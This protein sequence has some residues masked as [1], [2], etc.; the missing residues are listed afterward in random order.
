MPRSK[1]DYYCDCADHEYLLT[2]VSKSTWLCHRSR[3]NNPKAAAARA[4]R[5]LNDQISSD[6]EEGETEQGDARDSDPEPSGA[7]DEGRISASRANIPP[8]ALLSCAADTSH[9]AGPSSQS[10]L[11]FDT[12]NKEFHLPQPS[13]PHRP[14]VEEIPNE[15]DIVNRDEPPTL[16][17]FDVPPPLDADEETLANDVYVNVTLDN[18]RISLTFIFGLANAS[19]DDPE[20][21]L[22]A[23][24]VERIRNPPQHQLSLDEDPDLKAAVKLYLKLSHA[25]KDYE[26]A[27]EVSMESKD[28]EDFPTL[29]QAKQAVEQLSGVSGMMHDMCFNLCIGFTGQFAHLESCP[30]CGSSRYD[31]LILAQ[32]SGKKKVACKQFPTV[33]IGPQLQAMF[34]DPQSA[35]DMQYREAQ[36]RK[37]FE[38]LERN[39]GKVHVY[40][41]FLDGSDYINAVQEALPMQGIGLLEGLKIWDASRNIN[42]LSFPF[43]ALGTADGPGLAYLNGFVGHHGKNGCR[44][45]CGLRGRH[46]MGCTHY[47]PV[48]LKPHDYNV[49]GCSHPDVNVNDIRGA[50]AEMY[51]NNLIYVLQSSNETEYK[52]RR[53]ETGIS[54]PSIFL[55]FPAERTLG[56]PKCFGSDIMHLLLLNL[57]NLLLKLWRGTIECEPPDTK[58]SWYWASL[59]GN[60]WK[61]LG[62]DVADT[63]PYLPGSFDRVPR[64]IA[65]K[66]NS[67]Y[68]AWEFWLFL[69]G[70]GPAVLYKRLPD[71]IWEH[72]CRLV[73][74]VRIISQHSISCDKLCLANRLFLDWSKEFEMIYYQRLPTR[75]H[76]VWQSVHAIDHYGHEVETKGPLICASQWTME[77]TIGNLIEEIQQ[78]SNPYA[79]LGQRAIRRAQINA[80]KSIIPSLDTS[81]T[82][83]LPCFAKDL[84]SGYALLKCQ[85]WTSRATTVHE[86]WAIRD[87]IKRTCFDS[88]ILQ[89]FSNDGTIRV[90]RWARL[91]LPN[92]Q[93]ARSLW[94]ET[95]FNARQS[96]NVKIMLDGKPRVG[97]V[98]YYIECRIDHT[99]PVE[100]LAVIKLFSL[101]H[102]ELLRQPHTTFI[103]CQYL[104]DAGTIVVNVKSIHS[105]VAMVPHK[106]NDEDR[107]YM[108]EKPGADVT[109]LGGYLEED[110]QIVDQQ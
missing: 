109:Y 49:A 99:R 74:A 30:I 9:S 27:R 21:G 3:R 108:V 37:I 10:N 81:D 93:I 85:D 62:K 41:D 76:F 12:G 80:L 43:L 14:T 89:Q 17:H 59:T 54:K 67:G 69:Y 83:H 100:A 8:S 94:K 46:K 26:A 90:C 47:Y 34:R 1:K 57:P 110:E 77:H 53:L 101:P 50:S 22:N 95:H 45:Y 68:K 15:D 107:F 39:E 106:L 61:A 33:P 25:E 24:A 13:S 84:G 16:P 56:I 92:G 72:F 44:L 7:N 104:G 73:H 35:I 40:E 5:S 102:Q 91:Q 4:A 52:Q 60:T 97:E 58:A 63:R 29:Y 64:N 36:T 88:P 87:Y 98:Q 11:D 82:K 2:H 79:N 18:L 103:S 55:G 70:L 71:D 96:R 20:S 86:G 6:E 78:P 19:L 105:V 65:E 42:Y 38:E 66:I 75:I 23:A 48:L 31:Q 51:W 32:S 28:I